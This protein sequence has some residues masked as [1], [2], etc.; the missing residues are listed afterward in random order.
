MPI[1]PTPMHYRCRACGWNKTVSPR[2]DALVPGQDYLEAC[3]KCGHSPLDAEASGHS[4]SVAGQ[5][6]G[7]LEKWLK[8]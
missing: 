4:P 5:V 7:K 8:R 6:L 1:R 3:P 2:N